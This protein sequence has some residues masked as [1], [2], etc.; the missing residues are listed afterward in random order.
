MSAVP[1][2]TPNVR[3]RGRARRPRPTRVSLEVPDL[4]AA[5]ERLEQEAVIL[6]QKPHRREMDPAVRVV[7]RDRGVAPVGQEGAELVVQRRHGAILSGA[8]AVRQKAAAPCDA[9]PGGGSAP[10]PTLFSANRGGDLSPLWL[11]GF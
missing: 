1:E 7:R 3:F 10:A 6:E 2:R 8:G 11:P 4:P 5:A 9:P